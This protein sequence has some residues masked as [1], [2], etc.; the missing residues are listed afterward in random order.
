MRE[1]AASLND[2]AEEW[3]VAGS[4]PEVDW[5]RVRTLE[6][7]ETLRSRETLMQRLQRFGCALC[8]KFEQHVSDVAIKDIVWRSLTKYSMQCCTARKSYGGISRR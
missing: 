5:G 7:Q 6:F 1:A 4:V 8:E 2:L 3:L